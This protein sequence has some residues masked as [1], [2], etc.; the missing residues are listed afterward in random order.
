[1]GLPVAIG[2]DNLPSPVGIGLTDLI[3]LGGGRQCTVLPI[4]VR[5]LPNIRFSSYGP[6]QGVN[7][8]Q[9]TARNSF[10]IFRIHFFYLL[11]VHSV[12]LVS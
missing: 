7:L 5:P 8:A 2:G 4:I 11:N 10:L 3:I 9:N 1:M 6:V 12:I